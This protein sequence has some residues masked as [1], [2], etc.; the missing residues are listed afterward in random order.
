MSKT[1]VSITGSISLLFF[2]IIVVVALTGNGER[3]NAWMEK[4]NGL[5][6]LLANI[7]ADWWIVATFIN[8]FCY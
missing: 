1:V 7:L 5:I 3:L 6:V 2:G 8:L 4:Q